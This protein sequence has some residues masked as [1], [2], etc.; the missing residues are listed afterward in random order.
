MTF[1][2]DEQLPHLL[3]SWLQTKGFDTLH[4]TALLTN[5]H[6]PDNYICER[7]MADERVE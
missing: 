1:L 6:I 4:V 5:E 3:A 7:S 2:F